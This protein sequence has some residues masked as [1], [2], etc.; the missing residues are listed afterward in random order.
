M[1]ASVIIPTY[2]RPTELEVCLASIARQSVKPFE[3]V[4]I[5][6]GRLEAVPGRHWL[7]AAGI[8]CVYRRK[9]V[10]GLT[11]SR[12]LGVDLARGDVLFFLDDDVV[13]HPDYLK[14]VLATYRTDGKILGVGGLIANPKPKT[15]AHHLRYIF[16]LLFLNRGVREGT[17]LSSGFCTD[18]GSTWFPVKRARPVDFFDGGVSSFRKRVFKGRRFVAGYR[19]VGLGEDKDF[20]FGVSRSGLLV[21]NPKARLNHYESLKMRPD[22]YAWGRKFVLGRYLF[23]RD[24]IHNYRYDW[25][26]FIYALAG[27]AMARTVIAFFSFK[28][29]E[30]RR[31][32][33]ILRAV[34]DIHA[35]RVPVLRD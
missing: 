6:D 10:P 26:F 35:G 20:S 23:F 5:D 8:G 22:K 28:K 18:Y 16:D 15:A 7:D 2:N 21:V 29:A 9:A 32:R 27:Y 25:A 12:N 14:E 19:D 4:I 11:E 17:A 3:V 13:L 1:K 31:V 33:G 30:W 34:R 24:H